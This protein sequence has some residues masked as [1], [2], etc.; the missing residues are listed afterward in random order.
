M[1]IPEGIIVGAKLKKVR[2]DAGLTRIKLAEL[3]GIS[4][5][6]IEAYEQGKN[7]INKAQVNTLKPIAK[8]LNCNIED[9]LDY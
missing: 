5:R 1:E 8:A 3:S 6:L 7:D 2:A 9:L 4:F